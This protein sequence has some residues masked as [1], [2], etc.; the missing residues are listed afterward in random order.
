MKKHHLLLLFFLIISSFSFAQ[1][2]PRKD[3]VYTEKDSLVF[4]DFKTTAAT[5]KWDGLPLNELV[6]K[7]GMYFLNTPYVAHTLELSQ[8]EKLVVNLRE[9]DCTTFV[10]SCFALARTIHM[11][12]NFDTYCA[13]LEKMRYRDGIKTDY[14]SRNHYFTEWIRDNE[15]LGLV[16]DMT[17]EIGGVPLK[18]KVNFM[19]THPDKYMQLANNP[20]FVQRMAPIEKEI[21]ARNY[22][23]ISKENLPQVEKGIKT[24]DIIAIT[25]NMDGLDISHVGYAIWQNG[26][27][28]FMHASSAGKK[29]MIS[30]KTLFEYLSDITHH[31]GVM[32]VRIK[33]V[34]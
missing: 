2:L 32:V 21:S 7:A 3:R 13:E 16:K 6:V 31:T 19:S 20:D 10:E 5:N 28:H 18:V 30:D 24:G 17:Q 11:G 23:Y 29:V 34:E 22:F 25:T 8:E 26:K 14:P 9:F 27:L 33:N 1:L 15:Q 12:K 4:V